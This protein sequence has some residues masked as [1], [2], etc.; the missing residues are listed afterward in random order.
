MSAV[1]SAMVAKGLRK[2]EVEPDLIVVAVVS[3]ESDLTMTNPSWIVERA[4]P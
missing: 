3:T 4:N 2:V 1:D